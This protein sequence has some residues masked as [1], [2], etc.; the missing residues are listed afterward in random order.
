MTG[1]ID[2]SQVKTADAQ[3]TDAQNEMWERIK[4][5]RDRRQVAGVK[6]GDHWYHSDHASRVQFVALVT[7]GAGL[8]AGTMWKTRKNATWIKREVH[9]STD[10]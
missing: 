4:A 3:L 10:R 1:A 6:V 9:P 7:M 5:E 8:P 2:W